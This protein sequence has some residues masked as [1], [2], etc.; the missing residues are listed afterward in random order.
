MSK[1]PWPWTDRVNQNSQSSNGP[2][3]WPPETTLLSVNIV[4]HFLPHVDA[5][6]WFVIHREGNILF[7]KWINH[8]IN[9]IEGGMKTTSVSPG[10][11][12]P[13]SHYFQDVE[14]RERTETHVSK[15]QCVKETTTNPTGSPRGSLGPRS[16]QD[17]STRFSS[18]VMGIPHRPWEDVTPITPLSNLL[19]RLKFKFMKILISL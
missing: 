4:K 12:P 16:S 3:K 11:S 6:L 10:A 17:L 19:Q 13:S 7:D 18:N 9:D 14:G 1:C 15:E 5:I 2:R 8:M